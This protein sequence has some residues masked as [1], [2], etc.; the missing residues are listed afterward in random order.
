MAD[1]I[2]QH[3]FKVVETNNALR[4]PFKNGQYIIQDDGKVYYDPTTGSTNSAG[5]NIEDRILIAGDKNFYS[6]ISDR[7]NDDAYYYNLI[8]DAN[9]NDI[10]A[11]S[12]LKQSGASI[13]DDIYETTLY[14]CTSIDN[15]NNK[16]WNKIENEYDAKNIYLTDDIVSTLELEGF[17]SKDGLITIPGNGKNLIDFMQSI[18][19]PEKLPT[20]IQP[21]ATLTL[22][23]SKKNYE[24]GELVE[25][26]Y[27][28]T[29]NPG[30]YEFG[31]ETGVTITSATIVDSFGVSFDVT[32]SKSES[33][34]T[35]R[36]NTNMPYNLKLTL[37][38]SVAANSPN[39]LPSGVY[40]DGT[41][42]ENSSN[43][44]VITS[45]S[46][47]SYIEGCYCGTSTDIIT[48]DNITSDIIRNLSTKTK[49]NY[50]KGIKTF[51]VP[52]GTKTIIIAYPSSKTGV[53]KIL[54]TTVNADMTDA[55]NTP[56]KKIVAGADNDLTSDYVTEYNV[57]LYHPAE[58]YTIEATLNVTLS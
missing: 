52:V 26:S 35:F 41:I 11:I 16:I 15:E 49:A 18:L 38:H 13:E 57:L 46:L 24:V 56:F 23:A 21:S 31:P 51:T 25:P 48:E 17:E 55:F 5:S 27:T 50:K 8:S 43:A 45:D 54:N 1:V 39:K 29:W 9:V 36:A 53:S 22:T 3:L 19:C 2:T 34:S 37:T 6:N 44:I 42:R 12:K 28:F 33:L 40:E 47:T 10:C 32:E 30:S 20:I 7:T 4:V 14:I 58:A